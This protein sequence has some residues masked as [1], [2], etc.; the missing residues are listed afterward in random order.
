MPL[1]IAQSLPRNDRDKDNHHRNAAVTHHIRYR[2]ARKDAQK[3]RCACQ[4]ANPEAIVHPVRGL[5]GD[6]DRDRPD[7]KGESHGLSGF[8]A[9]ILTGCP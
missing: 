8:P 7:R 1:R 3:E 4:D 2:K 9:L 5:C 6:D